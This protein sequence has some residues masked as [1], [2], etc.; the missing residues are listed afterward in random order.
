MKKW[1]FLLLIIFLSS[2]IKDLQDTI[3]KVSKTS[4]INWSPEIAIPLLYTDLG[5]DDIVE[6]KDDLIEHRV[7]NDKSP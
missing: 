6:I 7:E 1:Q 4:T 3:N 2:C 5:V